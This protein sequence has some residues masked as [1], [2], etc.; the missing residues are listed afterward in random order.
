MELPPHEI[1]KLV[2]DRSGYREMLRLTG[3]EEDL[4]RLA[5]VEELISAAKQFADENPDAV[6]GDF[7]EQITLASDVRRL[8]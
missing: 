6:L 1:I 8:G 5:N 4:D 7:L 3:D 2:I